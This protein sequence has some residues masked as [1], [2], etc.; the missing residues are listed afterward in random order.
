M[1]TQASWNACTFRMAAAEIGPSISSTLPPCRM[2]I[3]RVLN[4]GPSSTV[5]GGK[6]RP[7]NSVIILSGTGKAVG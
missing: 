1:D 6:R 2:G 4:S 3:M 7:G 5:G